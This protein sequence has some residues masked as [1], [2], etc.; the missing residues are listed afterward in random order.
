MSFRIFTEQ[1]ANHP[2]KMANFFKKFRGYL[3]VLVKITIET[4]EKDVKPSPLYAILAEKEI[5]LGSPVKA[6]AVAW[7]PLIE[8]VL[9]QQTKKMLKRDGEF[10]Q[11]GNQ[12]LWVARLPKKKGLNRFECM[13]LAAGSA[14]DA[15][16]SRSLPRLSFALNLSGAA[17]IRA[18]LEGL[19]YADYDFNKYKTDSSKTKTETE[20]ALIV[21]AGDRKTADAL[22]AEVSAVF[23]HMRNLRDWVNEPGS[24]LDPDTFAKIALALGRKHGLSVTVRDEKKLQKEG[25]TGLWT[26][27]K[28]SNRPPRMVTLKY[29]GAKKGS[30]NHLCIVGKGITFDTGG[31]SLKPGAN[32]GDMKCDMAGAATALAAVCAAAEL[33]L[34]INVSAVL[35]L[36]ENRPGN[37]SVLP[38]DIFKA[39]NGKTIMVDNTDAEGRLVLTDGLFEAGNLK[40]T[41]IIDLATLTGSVVRA[42]GPWVTGLF[43]NDRNFGASIQKLGSQVDEK[44]WEL[45]ME[46][47]YR[48]WMDDVVADLRNAGKSEAGAIT[49]ALFLAEFVPAGA[50]WSHWDIAGTAFATSPWKYFKH[51]ATGFGLKT[52]IEIARDLA[53]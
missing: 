39:R 27:G 51:G 41:H 31:I 44:F 53:G 50:K 8:K 9:S 16:V 11:T 21:K 35:C 3:G 29:Q 47:E 20:I 25:F 33:K 32:M 10:F 6:D 28:G 34:P 46:E 4:F 1:K 13:R 15:A 2:L 7:Q 24:T 30:K 42:L 18:V 14:L 23:K 12:A 45:P 43:A 19:F 40:A 48:D 38:G 17:E 52:L 5:A 36:A 22:L 37:A 49:A 26:V